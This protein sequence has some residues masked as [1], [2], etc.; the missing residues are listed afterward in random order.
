[1]MARLSISGPSRT[2]AVCTVLASVVGEA[3]MN[4]TVRTSVSRSPAIAENQRSFT[5]P[6]HGYP[7]KPATFLFGDHARFEISDFE[8]LPIRDSR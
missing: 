5:S 8:R 2:A 1:M 4:H 3:H 6:F 7:A